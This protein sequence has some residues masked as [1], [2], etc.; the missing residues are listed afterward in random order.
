MVRRRLR[1][2]RHGQFMILAALGIV[3]MMITLASLLS[4]TSV[5]T[6]R[7]EKRD[8]REVTTQVS[9]NFRRALA[10][11]LAGVSKD[12]DFKASVRRYIN[13]TTLEEWPQAK[14]KGYE[15]LTSWQNTTLMRHPGLGLNLTVSTPTFTCWW[16][17]SWGYSMA[18]A[19]IT[20]DV[21]SYGFY[22][23]KGRVT[24]ELNATIMGLNRTDG[25]VTSFYLSLKRENGIP[26]CELTKPLVRILFQEENGLF[27]E[28]AQSA[29]NLVYFGDG[30]YLLS[31]G[32]GMMTIPDGLNLTK[33]YIQN[34]TEEEFKEAYRP[35]ATDQL[36]DMID[37]VID[38]YNSS[39][40]AEAYNNLTYDIRPKLD[41]A[42]PD[43]W[44]LSNANTTHILSQI[45]QV[46]SQLVPKIK[47]VLQDQRGI[48]VG[49]HTSLLKLGE[50]TAGPRTYDVSATPN[51]THGVGSTT[52]K[53]K[54]DD[55]ATG[56]SNIAGAEYFVGTVGADGTGTPMAASDRIFDSPTEEVRAQLNVTGWAVGNYT[57]YVH[58][59]DASGRWGSVSSVDLAVTETTFMYV[60]NIDMSLDIQRLW[61]WRWVR[62]VA[63]VTIMDTGGSPVEGA[64]VYGHWSGTTRGGWGERREWSQRKGEVFAVTDNDGQVTF[65]SR[66]IYGGGT[67]NFTVDDVVL[68]GWTY[69]SSLNVETSDSI[70]G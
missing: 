5:S 8:F 40:Y 41:P 38:K 23:W 31:F 37:Q 57:I 6:I 7:L 19:N 51:P 43:S 21:I 16:N 67:F 28:T 32:T 33:A 60:S 70:S 45:D 56:W 22:G 10:I 69:N 24:V 15:F 42:D 58:G 29:I 54:I 68:F 64:T 52:L 20:L 13:F 55:L 12:L 9:L 26:V 59:R 36:C 18:S 17:S 46:R 27:N 11:S 4:Y 48:V 14:N 25:N 53:A 1:R 34:M 50:D 63:T 39:Q 65:K 2:S 62:G 44:V 47:I 35:N 66:W 3:T 61:S 49:A 30:C